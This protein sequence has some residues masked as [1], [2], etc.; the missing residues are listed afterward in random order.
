MRGVSPDVPGATNHL[1]GE[2]TQHEVVPMAIDRSRD[3][4]CGVTETRDDG[5]GGMS[6]AI[7]AWRAWVSAG[8][9]H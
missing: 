2:T 5:R 4:A 8:R 7:A 6:F 3:V 1:R 9:Q